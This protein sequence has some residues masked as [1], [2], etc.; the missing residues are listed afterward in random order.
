MMIQK[1]KK[2]EW[3]THETENRGGCRERERERA[4]LLENKEELG[5]KEAVYYSCENKLNNSE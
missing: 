5:L 2:K 3:K 1:Q 4:A